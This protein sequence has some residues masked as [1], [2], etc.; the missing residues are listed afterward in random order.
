[1]ADHIYVS[2]PRVSDSIGGRIKQHRRAIL[3]GR[4]LQEQCMVPMVPHITVGGLY[5]SYPR[6]NGSLEERK[7]AMEQCLSLVRMVALVP[8]PDTGT[9][10]VLL[11]DDRTWAWECNLEFQEWIKHTSNNTK[12]TLW[13]ELGNLAYELGCLKEWEN[14]R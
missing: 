13:S 14:L 11:N 6:T 4:M 9:L 7:A 8:K 12:Q 2:A 3:L 10:M 1:M 5:P